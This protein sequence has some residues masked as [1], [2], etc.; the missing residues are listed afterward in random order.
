MNYLYILDINSYQLY[1]L[2]T[3][4]QFSRLLGNFVNGFLF[5][6]EAFDIVLLIIFAFLIFDLMS[7]PQSHSHD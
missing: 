2:Q 3:F 6:S 5:C 1:D 7:D 4:S